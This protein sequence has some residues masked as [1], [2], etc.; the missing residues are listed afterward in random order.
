MTDPSLIHALTAMAHG[1][2]GG[3]PSYYFAAWPVA[4]LFGSGEW[5][6]RM[7]SSVF[8]AAGFALLFGL[9]RRTYGLRPAMLAV[10]LSIGGSTLILYQNSEVRFYADLFFSTVVAVCGFDRIFRCA[11]RGRPAGR[12]MALNALGHALLVLT[13]PFGIAFSAAT[14]FAAMVTFFRRRPKHFLVPYLASSAEG[15]AFFAL[16][17]RGFLQQARMLG[18]HGTLPVPT[19]PDF[20]R[21][22]AQSRPCFIMTTIRKPGPPATSCRSDNT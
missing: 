20:F 10:T 6:I 12:A 8:V 1:A 2:D 11:Q 7:V 19:G 5:T 17:V 4:R 16:W 9:L 22:Y 3:F 21:V 14:S 18:G 13:H 15:G